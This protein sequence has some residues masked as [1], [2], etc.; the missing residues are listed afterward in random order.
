MLD[1]SFADEWPPVANWSDEQLEEMAVYLVDVDR[2]E[3]NT[4]EGHLFHWL[5]D[6]V[7]MAKRKRDVQQAAGA[8]DLDAALRRILDEGDEPL[9]EP[10]A[11]A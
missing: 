11:A 5:A 2:R 1:L 4:V 7:Y 6:A 3:L 10:D 8:L 9:D